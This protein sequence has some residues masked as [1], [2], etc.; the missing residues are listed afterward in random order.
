MTLWRNSST[1]IG[2]QG[3]GRLSG[4]L[5]SSELWAELRFYS[6]QEYVQISQLPVQESGWCWRLICVL[7]PTES[8]AY[9][10]M[11]QA[12][13]ASLRK[14]ECYCKKKKRKLTWIELKLAIFRLS[15]KSQAWWTTIQ[16]SNSSIYAIFAI[17][18][19]I[20]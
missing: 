16:A 2:S 14:D 6:Q 19:K 9:C 8:P 20:S 4:L 10:T 1:V 7:S 17:F 11:R 3:I 12:S 13:W 5:L 15:K 18:L